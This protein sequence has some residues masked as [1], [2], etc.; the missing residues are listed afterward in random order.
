MV[1]EDDGLALEGAGKN[2]VNVDN[3]PVKALALLGAK[4]LC[5]KPVMWGAAPHS[6]ARR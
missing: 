5:V 6:G 4:S 1:S 3:G 2:S